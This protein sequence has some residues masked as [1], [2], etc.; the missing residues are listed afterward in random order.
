[1]QP[2]DIARIAEW[3]RATDIGGLELRGPGTALR[4]R[5]D[6]GQVQAEALEAE[7]TVPGLIVNAPSLGVFLHRHPLR[8]DDLALP[9]AAVTAGQVLGLLQV[10]PL[11]LPVPA[12]ADGLLAD[13]LVPH[14]MTVG[15]GT[16]LAA[17]SPTE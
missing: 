8:G 6:A 17:L 15:Y 16:P 12:P 10:G 7:A 5:H 4:L 14:G 11:L 9:G 3:L 2:E 13:W 1:M